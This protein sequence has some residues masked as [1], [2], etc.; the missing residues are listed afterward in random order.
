[1]E[2]TRIEVTSERRRYPV[3]IG[4]G[5]T[6]RLRDLLAAH[7][8]DRELV[9]VTCP[10]VWRFHAKRLQAVANS[11]APTMIPDGERAKT[12]PTVARIYD[13][14]V[15]RRVDRSGTIIAFGGGVVGDV[16]GFAAATY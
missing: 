3:L 10:P 15:K 6:S 14:L 13:A 11:Q 5:V 9:V 4:A 7:G 1:M 2:P 12:L 16:A 8:M